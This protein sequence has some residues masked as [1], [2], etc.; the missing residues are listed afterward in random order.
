M[1]LMRRLEAVV[2]KIDRSSPAIRLRYIVEL[3]KILC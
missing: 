2:A 3:L 1:K